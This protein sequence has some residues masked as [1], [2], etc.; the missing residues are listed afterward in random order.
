MVSRMKRGTRG[1]HPVPSLSSGKFRG[2]ARR[3]CLM[4]EFLQVM[5]RCIGTSDPLGEIRQQRNAGG[6]LL[7]LTPLPLL[8]AMP[9]RW[10][11][12]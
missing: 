6:S 7:L 5:H 1:Q 11:P 4:Y 9:G 10:V 12:F 8:G 2:A 3:F